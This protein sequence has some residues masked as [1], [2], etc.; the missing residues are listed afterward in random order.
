MHYETDDDIPGYREAKEEETPEQ[1]A[2]AAFRFDLPPHKMREFAVGFGPYAERIRATYGDKDHYD[3]L[4]EEPYL[5]KCLPSPP[6]SPKLMF[7]SK[8]FEI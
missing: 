8:K 5:S 3:D 1:R 6:I 4:S 7:D 2:A